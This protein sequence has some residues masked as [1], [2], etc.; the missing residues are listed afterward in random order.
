MK[1]LSKLLAVTG[2]LLAGCSANVDPSSPTVDVSDE[3]VSVNA[4][5]CVFGRSLK[6]FRAHK[7]DIGFGITSRAYQF[8]DLTAEDRWQ[9]KAVYN[10]ADDNAAVKAFVN[11]MEDSE[12]F[13]E[14][15]SELGG[16]RTFRLIHEG[17][18]QIMPE[19]G[20]FVL[21]G[22]AAVVARYKN[23]DDVTGCMV[24]KLPGLDLRGRSCIF[25]DSTEDF[26]SNIKVSKKYTITEKTNL[27]TLRTA[28]LLAA[29]ER[30]D[31]KELVSNKFDEV[32]YQTLENKLTGDRFTRV[33]HYPGDNENGAIFRQGSVDVVARA[34]DGD[35]Y[36]CLLGMNRAR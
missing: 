18:G 8:E 3:A 9:L 2:V 12:L 5:E 29:S 30:Y 11:G 22:T 35:I 7:E 27:S 26:A 6:T 17:H 10:L 28:Q 36:E 33:W 19:S 24:T 34:G 31:L 25:G 32:H 21:G 13:I 23:Y 14:E 20:T 16:P 15:M 1:T 4:N